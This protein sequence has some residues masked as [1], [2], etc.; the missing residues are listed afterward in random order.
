MKGRKR[1]ECSG[2]DS[3]EPPIPSHPFSAMSFCDRSS[4]WPSSLSSGRSV[5]T[6]PWYGGSITARCASVRPSSAPTQHG[7]HGASHRTARHSKT[8]CSTTQHSTLIDKWQ[9]QP[10]GKR[11]RAAQGEVRSILGR[12]RDS[13]CVHQCSG[14]AFPALCSLS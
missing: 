3:R 12:R 5:K 9:R 7:M 13:V 1:K 10:R 8:Q 6:G 14:Q 2:S 4:S 11:V